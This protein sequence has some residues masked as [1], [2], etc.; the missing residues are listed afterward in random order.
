MQLQLNKSK[1]GSFILMLIV[2]LLFLMKIYFWLKNV[3]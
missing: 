3:N 1:G 2:Q